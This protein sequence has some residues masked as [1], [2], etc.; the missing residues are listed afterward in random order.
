[1]R[2]PGW[3]IADGPRP[4][5]PAR[6]P[7]PDARWGIG[8]WPIG[9]GTRCLLPTRWRCRAPLWYPCPSCRC[10]RA[11]PREDEKNPAIDGTSEDDRVA[12]GDSLA[13]HHDVNPFGWLEQ[14]FGRRVFEPAYLIGPR[15]GCIDD[16]AGAHHGALAGEPILELRADHP[17]G[18]TL[19][20][21]DRGIVRDQRPM[22]NGG[23][24]RRQH[25]PCIVALR[26]VEAAPRPAGR[27]R[28]ASARL[29]GARAC[30]AS[31]AVAHS[32]TGQRVVQPHARREPPECDRSPRAAGKMNCRGH[33]RWGRS[34]EESRRS[35]LAS[36]T[37]PQSAGLEVAKAPVNEPAGA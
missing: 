5:W 6:P 36:N 30:R 4:M 3:S 34:G 29:R 23:A 14:R 26:V 16:D 1:M 33:T 21:A 12:V 22:M 9:G 8:R 18:C 17:A 32:G 31:G 2:S 20:R 15:A 24:G 13:I 10:R 25:E 28:A 7:R 27:A 35:R 11:S 37:R 19:E